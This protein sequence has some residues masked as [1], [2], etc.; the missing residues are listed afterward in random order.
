MAKQLEASSPSGRPERLIPFLAW[1]LTSNARTRRFLAVAL[2][3]AVT[4]LLL[5]LATSVAVRL[6]GPSPLDTEI[7]TIL[8]E[9]ISVVPF[10][11]ADT[12]PTQIGQI[13]LYALSGTTIYR[14]IKRRYESSKLANNR[15]AEDHSPSSQDQGEDGDREDSSPLGDQASQKPLW[16]AQLLEQ[17]RRSE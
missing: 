15:A 5:P 13:G 16:V 11:D 2:L 3:I 14:T 4:A 6:A 10:V 17:L 7:A 1:V 9:I 8:A 12:L